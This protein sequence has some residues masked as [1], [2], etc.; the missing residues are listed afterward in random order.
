MV[1]AHKTM[2]LTEEARDYE[3]AGS[4]AEELPYW[5]W[6]PDRRTCLTRG[7]QLLTLG[8]LTPAVVDGRTP[9]QLDRVADRWQRALSNLD[10]R[11]RLYFYLLRQPSRLEAK[12]EAGRPVVALSQ[13]RRCTFLSRRVSELD[14]YLDRVREVRFF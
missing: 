3:A 8:R 1:C 14:T 6:L 4:L 2:N 13:R 5:G 12:Q 9:E 7:G 10:E 11:T